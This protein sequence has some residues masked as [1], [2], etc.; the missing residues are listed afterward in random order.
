MGRVRPNARFIVAAASVV[1]V[2]VAAVFVVT[3]R[4][5]TRA[6][7]PT[8]DA[9][10]RPE[11][12]P[13]SAG[14]PSVAP[15][16]APAPAPAPED[17]FAAG[18]RCVDEAMAWIARDG[19][20]LAT[21]STLVVEAE[22]TRGEPTPIGPSSERYVYRAPDLFRSHCTFH[23][24]DSA[25]QLDRDEFRRLVDRLRIESGPRFPWDAAEAEVRAQRRWVRAL[26]VALA[27]HGAGARF[28]LGG[29][30]PHPE[31]PG[32]AWFEVVRTAPGDSTQTLYFRAAPRPD[33][34]GLRAIAPDRIVVDPDA[35]EPTGS[36]EYA[37]GGWEPRAADERPAAYRFPT[38][39]VRTR[40]SPDPTRPTVSRATVRV[41]RID[42]PIEPELFGA[43]IVRRAP[44]GGR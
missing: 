33:R 35:D 38:E 28:R 16:T 43:S 11:V 15:A 13:A 6:P 26:A 25:F 34:R 31:A 10:P 41:L 14:E 5:R 2:G 42:E 22:V 4:D 12:D 23:G 27:P 20:V 39:L 24:R 7:A 29:V 32:G 30:L 17:P 21:V 18:E 9:A 1:I 40:R 37:F 19:P 8:A 36:V 44:P 3:S